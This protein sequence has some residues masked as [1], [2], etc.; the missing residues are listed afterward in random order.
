MKIGIS[1]YS[2]YK[3]TRKGLIDCFGIIEKTKE[4]GFDAIE[5]SGMPGDT[6]EERYKMA[7]D[8]KKACD[9]CNLLITN[10]C[11]GADLV[12]GSNWNLQTEI[13]RIKKE[14]DIAAV[15][16]V[17]KM[18]HD[19]SFGFGATDPK[20]RPLDMYLDRLAE[21]CKK[22]TEYAKGANI[23]T[24][25]ENHGRYCQHSCDVLSIYR[26][27]DDDN[28][29]ILLDIGNFMCV[30]QDPVEAVAQLAPYAFHVHAKDFHFK[31][32]IN[33]NPG[34]GW[35]LTKHGNYLRGSIIGHGDVPLKECINILKIYGYDDVLSIEFEG[36]EDVL[37][38][39]ENGQA[40]LK[41]LV[42]M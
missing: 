39:I 41:N 9:D 29:G 38:A 21:G 6:Y 4:F 34:W 5:F 10:Y 15:L 40:N 36:I 22:L 37:S 12:K 30:D 24:M 7:K 31:S 32:G 25:I 17:S 13:D 35:F 18:R 19:A 8:I 33:M 14:I 16:G 28:F 3:L 1:S 26:A 11:T 23:R 2:Y 42:D 20:A 27:V